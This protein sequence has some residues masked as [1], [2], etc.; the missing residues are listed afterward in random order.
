MILCLMPLFDFSSFFFIKRQ[1]LRL[2]FRR[3]TQFYVATWGQVSQH[4]AVVLRQFFKPVGSEQHQHISET[5]PT[6]H[7]DCLQKAIAASDMPLLL[8]PDQKPKIS[9]S[10]NS[11]NFLL[12]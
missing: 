6:L 1:I 11:H 7:V 3:F 5:S 8:L 12:N 2:H 4:S 9:F 10:I